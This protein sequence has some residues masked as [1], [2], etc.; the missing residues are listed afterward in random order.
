MMLRPILRAAWLAVIAVASGPQ[1]A[2]ADI[3]TW[4]DASGSINV[5]NLAPPDGVR[6]ISVAH[7]SP[8]AAAARENAVREAA[9]RVETQ[10]LE[11]RVRKLESEAAARRQAPTQVVYPTI[12]PPPPMQ[13]WSEPAPS[14]QYAVSAAPPTYT[15][16]CDPSWSSCGLG[17]WPGFY[18]TSVVFVRAP[19]FRRFP[20]TPI[21]HHFAARQPMRPSGHFGRG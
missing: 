20:A 15:Q 12:P 16:G 7:A 21:R 10:A 9:R 8:Q 17:W 3:Y 2:H 19:N 5:S 18:P 14:L 4:A 11:E 1:L 13:Y 6:V